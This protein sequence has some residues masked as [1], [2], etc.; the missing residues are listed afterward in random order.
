MAYWWWRSPTTTNYLC[1]PFTFCF[2]FQS[3]FFLN[4]L[5][6]LSFVTFCFRLTFYTGDTWHVTKRRIFWLIDTYRVCQWQQQ[7]R[8]N[9]AHFP[10]HYHHGWLNQL[11]RH[12]G[13]GNKK[14]LMI[15]SL[16]IMIIYNDSSLSQEFFR[17]RI[18]ITT[19]TWSSCAFCPF[20]NASSIIIDDQMF[21][22]QET[23]LILQHYPH[24][25][26]TL[27]DHQTQASHRFQSLSF[28]ELG[29]N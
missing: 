11:F 25:T 24:I 12:T 19:T 22:G 28:Y 14:I 1:F 20:I 10:H 17:N 8:E 27:N 23:F 18:L 5:F 29:R 3:V 16:M 6:I 21:E 9:S 15:P 13:K 7:W 26:Y 4:F 2:Q